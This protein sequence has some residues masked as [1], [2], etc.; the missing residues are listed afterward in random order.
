[1]YRL[2]NGFQSKEW[3]VIHNVLRGSEYAFD[4]YIDTEVIRHITAAKKRVNYMTMD[5]SPLSS[6]IK[7]ARI[8][9]GMGFCWR[10]PL[11][12]IPMLVFIR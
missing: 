9:N 4:R 8:Y 6:A 10:N 7:S 3:D 11:G 12:P 2:K 1:L 5:P